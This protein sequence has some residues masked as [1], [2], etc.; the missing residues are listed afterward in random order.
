MLELVVSGSIET[1]QLKICSVAGSKGGKVCENSCQMCY[2]E[3][4]EILVM[5]SQNLG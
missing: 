2:D 1:S 3:G 4:V 5:F